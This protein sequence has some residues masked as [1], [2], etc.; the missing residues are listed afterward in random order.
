MLSRFLLLPAAIVPSALHAF[1]ISEFHISPEHQVEMGLTADAECLD[2][3]SWFENVRATVEHSET[4][5]HV[6][7]RLPGKADSRFYRVV[8]LETKTTSTRPSS[9]S[10]ASTMNNLPTASKAET[11]AS[12]T[13]MEKSVSRFWRSTKLL[14]WKNS[15]PLEDALKSSTMKRLLAVT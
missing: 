14:A 2:G 1:E 5:V 8:G 15:G 4:A 11:F 3:E 7:T 9:I 6:F 12:P 10:S 13:S